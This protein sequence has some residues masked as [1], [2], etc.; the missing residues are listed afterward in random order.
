MRRNRWLF[1]VL[2]YFGYILELTLFSRLA[3]VILEGN[4]E[5]RLSVGTDSYEVLQEIDHIAR[6][7]KVSPFSLSVKMDERTVKVTGYAQSEE[8][9]DYEVVLGDNYSDKQA[10]LRKIREVAGSS[11]EF[12]EFVKQ[13][14][15]SNE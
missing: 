8:F 2:L 7:S 6:M 9:R 11:E 10:I 14:M 1:A 3:N 4:R 5:I 13:F 12:D 15:S